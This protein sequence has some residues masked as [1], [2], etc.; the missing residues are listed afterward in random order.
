MK[1]VI[2]IPD[3]DGPGL[4]KIVNKDN[5][6]LYIGSSQNIK[7]RALQHF[8]MLE[9]GNHHCKKLQSDY[10]SGYNFEFCVIKKIHT[11]FLTELRAQEQSEMKKYSE[12]QLYNTMQ[13]NSFSGYMRKDHMV[14]IFA[15]RYCHEKYGVSV[16]NLLRG[17]DAEIEMRFKI[18]NNPENE[19]K[20]RSEYAEVVDYKNKV[21]WYRSAYGIDY[22]EYIDLPKKDRPKLIRK[23]YF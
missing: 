10:N 15:D 2:Y 20:I 3:Y 13:A 1:D 17:N 18:V 21:E 23:K 8:T 11:T 5:G 19:M 16:L 6:K 22:D 9:C 4:Y 7:N 14:E 12:S